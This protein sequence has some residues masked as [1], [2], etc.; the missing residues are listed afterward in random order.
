MPI[1]V[2]Q[3]ISNILQKVGRLVLTGLTLTIAIGAFMGVTALFSSIDE[4]VAEVFD[5]FD[6]EIQMTTQEIEDFDTTSQLIM[7]NIDGVKQ[8]LPGYGV[9]VALEGYEAPEMGIVCCRNQSG[10]G[11]WLRHLNRHHSLPLH[12][13]HGLDRTTPTV[14]VWF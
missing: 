3:A 8:V 1:S 11:R 2:R 14:R 6:T 7:D 5:T 10:A 9:S 13:R 12:F 4:A